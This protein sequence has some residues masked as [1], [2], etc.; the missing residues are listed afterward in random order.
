MQRLELHTGTLNKN[1]HFQVRLLWN[2]LF[3]MH[4]QARNELGTL[5]RA[6]SFLRG[7]QIF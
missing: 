5:G 3:I 6:K 2:L 1:T 4:C 7:A